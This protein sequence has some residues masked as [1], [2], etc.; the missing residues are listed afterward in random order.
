[1][2]RTDAQRRANKKYDDAHYSVLTAKVPKAY[3]EVFR[4]LC[5]SEGK[6]VSGKLTEMLQAYVRENVGVLDSYI[7]SEE[8]AE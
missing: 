1:M 5:V 6:S 4:E 8:K 2:P 7:R 3:A